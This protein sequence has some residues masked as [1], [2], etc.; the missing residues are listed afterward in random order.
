MSAG[1][2]LSACSSLL[3]DLL[4]TWHLTSSRPAGEFLFRTSQYLF[5]AFHLI[6]PGPPRII[7]LSLAQ[8]QLNWS[9]NY[10][11]KISLLLTYNLITGVIPHHIHRSCSY[12]REGNCTGCTYRGQESQERRHLGILPATTFLIFCTQMAFSPQEPHTAVIVCTQG[13]RG[14]KTGSS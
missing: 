10:I 8:N 1:V 2:I 7:S 14:Q 11:C 3:C 9:F 13:K 6:M 12:G 4:T 5:M